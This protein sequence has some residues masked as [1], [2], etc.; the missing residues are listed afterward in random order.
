MLSMQERSDNVL[1]RSSLV[2]DTQYI[3]LCLS[4]PL[5]HTAAQIIQ[6]LNWENSCCIMSSNSIGFQY[7]TGA[8]L[9]NCTHLLYVNKQIEKSGQRQ[10]HMENGSSRRNSIWPQYAW[11]LHNSPLIFIANYPEFWPKLYSIL[12]SSLPFLFV[13][14][15]SWIISCTLGGCNTTY[16]IF[17]F[18]QC[19]VFKC[20]PNVW[21]LIRHLHVFFI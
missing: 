10:L 6:K 12:S 16:G 19:C 18:M 5:H 1:I 15:H 21:H 9:G 3:S 11:G 17:M 14:A 20:F 2:N 7:K 4:F 13:V 8:H